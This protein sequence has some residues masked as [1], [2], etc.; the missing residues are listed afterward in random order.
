MSLFVAKVEEN[1]I[2]HIPA[3]HSDA[4]VIHLD[5]S[6]NII[7][8]WVPQLH[9]AQIESNNGDLFVWNLDFDEKVVQLS[10]IASNFLYKGLV[11]LEVY[12]PTLSNQRSSLSVPTIE[13]VTWE[14]TD[15]NLQQ[16]VDAI[17]PADVSGRTLSILKAIVIQASSQHDDLQNIQSLQT[18]LASTAPSR[19]EDLTNPLLFAN[20]MRNR[21]HLITELA[22]QAKKQRM[23]ILLGSKQSYLEELLEGF[24]DRIEETYSQELTHVTAHFDSNHFELIY[25]TYKD[26]YIYPELDSL[27]AA[28]AFAAVNGLKRKSGAFLPGIF[29][30]GMFDNPVNFSKAYFKTVKQ[31]ERDHWECISHLLEFLTT[32]AQAAGVAERI[33]IFLPFD[34]V[35]KIINGN[36]SARHHLWEGLRELQQRLEKRPEVF[37][38]LGIILAVE[39]LAIDRMTEPRFMRRVMIIPPLSRAEIGNLLGRFWGSPASDEELNQ[40]E[41]NTG[42]DPW[43]LYLLL[44]CLKVVTEEREKAGNTVRGKDAI[45][46]ACTL[47]LKAIN[48]HTSDLELVPPDVL[49]KINNYLE[50]CKPILQSQG[51]QGANIVLSAWEHGDTEIS[52]EIGEFERAWIRTGLVYPQDFRET[53]GET[54]TSLSAYPLYQF[55]K[56]GR[57]PLVF[58]KRLLTQADRR[59]Q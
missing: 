47:F 48:A 14:D 58:A 27:F 13:P 52:R 54:L 53:R 51:S 24:E 50:V 29:T 36:D 26:I 31:E 15:E 11:R 35:D 39:D 32:A 3:S 30:V 57:L 2:D 1:G 49:S 23:V 55:C 46:E 17:N 12:G 16:V 9:T 59:N 4:T 34:R 8:L 28:I 18:W 7:W 42:G 6:R 19:R 37:P 43:F 22:L 45:G 44:R 40:I 25:N 20:A 5:D 33:T 41:D 21:P 56:A 38:H 10:K